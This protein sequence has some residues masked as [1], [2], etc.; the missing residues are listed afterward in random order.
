MIGPPVALRPKKRNPRTAVFSPECGF[1][2]MRQPFLLVGVRLQPYKGRAG[3]RWSVWETSLKIDVGNG[4][5]DRM[6]GF[7]WMKRSGSTQRETN[8]Y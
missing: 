6:G 4:G 7:Y 2:R 5:N 1:Y 3:G 8:L